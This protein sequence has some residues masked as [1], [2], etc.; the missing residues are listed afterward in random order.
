M[1][2]VLPDL[3]PVVVLMTLG[4]G[5]GRTGFFTDPLIEG[6][7]R[8]VV[9]ISLPTLLFSAFSRL[10]LAPSF[11]ILALVVFASCGL[12]GLAA[13]PIAKKLHL[14][15]PASVLL[16]QGYEAGMLGYALFSSLYGS[17]FIYAFATADMGHV[18]YVFTVLMAQ[19]IAGET[20]G[21]VEPL[22]LLKRLATSPVFISIAAGLAAAAVVPGAFGTPWA[23]DG[24]LAPALSAIGSLTTPL[25]C[26]VVDY[27]LKDGFGAATHWSGFAS[28]VKM[29]A[30]RFLAS[31][32]VGA[33]VAILI[34]PAL[35]FGKAYPLAVMTLFLLPPPFVVAVFRNKGADSAYVSM[36]LSLHTL[37]SLVAVIVVALFSGGTL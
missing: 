13:G 16:F 26:I 14:L 10:Y 11:F 17:S 24:F 15:R 22:P 20:G 5:L 21:A 7:R 19:L 6:L 25:V 34:V 35:G 18:V 3:L 36:T 32:A 28:C 12:L 9:T 2:D 4:A 33:V 37:V 30:V 29:V 23:K 8:L 31:F 27:G 1:A